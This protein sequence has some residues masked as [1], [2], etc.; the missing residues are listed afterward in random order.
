MNQ[1]EVLLQC[2]NQLNA[3]PSPNGIVTILINNSP[4]TKYHS[5]ICPRLSES[6]PQIITKD[7]IEFAIDF[8]TGLNDRSYRIGYNSLGAFASV[9]HL[10]M[11]LMH[12]PEK[13][14]IEDAVSANGEN[15]ERSSSSRQYLLRNVYSLQNRKSSR[16]QPI[17]TDWIFQHLHSVYQYLNGLI[18]TM[19][20][21]NWS[22]SPII[23]VW[24]QYR[25]I[26]YGHGAHIRI[27]K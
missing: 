13:L 7:S 11:H 8:I 24:I 1:C 22:R 20:R 27:D 23:S 3:N 21:V 25:T 26:S 5:L 14:F 16:L 6:L 10:H 19:L 15:C 9:N 4:L 18:R 17:F 2:Q 12:V